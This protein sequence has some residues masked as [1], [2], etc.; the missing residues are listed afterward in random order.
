M[1]TH[2]TP[3]LS[4]ALALW[5]APAERENVPDTAAERRD[6]AALR[7]DSVWN[8]FPEA[9]YRIQNQ[10]CFLKTSATEAVRIQVRISWPAFALE[11]SGKLHERDYFWKKT[12]CSR[13][14]FLKRYLDWISFPWGGFTDI[15]DC[16]QV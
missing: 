9:N 4:A 16:N 15:R 3:L 2:Y 10:S 7:Q 12:T 1:F 11:S 5:R 6:I 14:S 13:C 8:E